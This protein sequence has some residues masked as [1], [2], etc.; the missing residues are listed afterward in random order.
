M[1]CPR[2]H[3]ASALDARSCTRCGAPLLF[4]DDP[5]PVPLDLAL[6]LDRRYAGRRLTSGPSSETSG[7][8]VEE[9][10]GLPCI[11]IPPLVASCEPGGA[12]GQAEA[13]DPLS[14]AEEAAELK[15]GSAPG[16]RRAAA[17]GIDL[18]V[19]A[20]A[21]GP[22]LLL[23]WYALPAGPD[24]LVTLVPTFAAFTALL[25]FAYAALGHA[26]MGATFGKRLLGLQVVGP[27][28]AFPGLARSAA[29]SGLAV[30]GAAGLGVGVLMALFT[31]SGRSLHD[32]IADTVVIRTP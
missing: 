27:D 32:L 18:M 29:R 24:I 23:A 13:P 8:D 12:F 15:V 21:G 3:A 22:P 4:H 9:G 28:G 16:W 25:G 14:A 31:R 6:R 19:L 10:A 11:A 20:T 30:M 1:P 5:S 17:W 2:C 7:E 26:L